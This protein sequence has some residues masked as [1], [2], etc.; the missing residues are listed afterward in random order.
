MLRFCHTEGEPAEQTTASKQE[1]DPEK[2]GEG[3]EGNECTTRT[4]GQ[5]QWRVELTSLT[6]RDKGKKGNWTKARERKSRQQRPGQKSAQMLKQER[7]G[8]KEEPQRKAS[9]K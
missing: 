4:Y 2:W 5:I 1:K 9:K 3:K 6:T 7:M 8:R